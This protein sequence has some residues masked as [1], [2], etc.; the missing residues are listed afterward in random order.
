MGGDETAYIGLGSNE[1]E[2]ISFI[3][4]AVE[5]VGSLPGIRVLA[6]SSLFETAPVGMGGGLFINAVMAAAARTGPRRL[7]D[8]L[9]ETEAAMGRKREGPGPAARNIDLDLLLYGDLVIRE[10][11]LVVPHPGILDRRFVLE[12]LAQIAPGLRIPLDD[13]TFSETVSVLTEGLEDQEVVDIGPVE[14][15][16]KPDRGNGP[17][18]S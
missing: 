8:G 16:F 4:E 11:D 2:R 17:R 3:L 9:M 12:P 14:G 7:F 13:G 6:L 10:K 15:F 18:G 1:G 5:R